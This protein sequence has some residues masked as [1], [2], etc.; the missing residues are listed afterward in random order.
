MY[1]ILLF[2]YYILQQLLIVLKFVSLLIFICKLVF[3]TKILSALLTT[4]CII[5]VL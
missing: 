3:A 5:L 2:S 1:I 4:F